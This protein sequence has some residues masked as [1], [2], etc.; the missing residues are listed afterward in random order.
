ML[1]A[2]AHGRKWATGRARCWCMFGLY[3]CAEARAGRVFVGRRRKVAGSRASADACELRA[4]RSLCRIDRM[5][6]MGR[7]RQC[8]VARTTEQN[9]IN[10]APNASGRRT[11]GATR[12]AEREQSRPRNIVRAGSGVRTTGAASRPAGRHCN[13]NKQTK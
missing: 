3:V 13:N 10:L 1:I 4:R 8:Q 9:F 2:P 12:T 6:Q 5:G 7:R 11:S